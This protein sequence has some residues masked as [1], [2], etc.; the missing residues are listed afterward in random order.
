MWM[1]SWDLSL[2]GRP[3]CV[4]GEWERFAPRFVLV[5]VLSVERA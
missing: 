4:V 5:G 3:V 2:I 1:W